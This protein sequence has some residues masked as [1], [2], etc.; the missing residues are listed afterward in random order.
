M[1]LANAGDDAE[2]I[3]TFLQDA[4][5]SI[6]SL[7]DLSKSTYQSYP[8]AETFAPFPLQVVIDQ[9]GVIRYL[10]FQYEAEAV[11]HAIDALLIEENE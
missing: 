11:R 1:L 9:E 2:T 10:A 5:T 3:Q 7:M 8:Q 6:P 4:H